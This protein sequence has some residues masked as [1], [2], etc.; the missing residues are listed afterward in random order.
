MMRLLFAGVVTVIG[1]LLLSQPLSAQSLNIDLGV[2]TSIPGPPSSSFGGAA[3]QPGV[4][5]RLGNG[6]TASLPGL[7]GAATAV[8]ATVTSDDPTGGAATCTGDIG[9]LL[10]DFVYSSTSWS[11][12]LNG[13]ANGTYT[14][15]LYEP[16]D[17]SVVTGAMTVNGTPVAG[18]TAHTCNLNA[19]EMYTTATAS[20]TSGTLTITGSGSTPWFGLAGIQLVTGQAQAQAEVIPTASPG[21]LVLLATA[22]GALAIAKLRGWR[23]A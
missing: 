18:L 10:N 2:N 7:T 19:G 15:Y 4:W 11:V 20:V 14:V 21:A 17:E 8:S 3:S 13:L 12:V 22:L 5:S 1:G 23:R 16:E 9:L 6:T